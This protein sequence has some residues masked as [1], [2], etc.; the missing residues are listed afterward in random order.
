MTNTYEFAPPTLREQGT[1]RAKRPMRRTHPIHGLWCEHTEHVLWCEYIT[2][3]IDH[4]IIPR[5][6]LAFNDSINMY[7][8]ESQNTKAK[9][10]AARGRNTWRAFACGTRSDGNASVVHEARN[11]TSEPY[12]DR[13][14]LFTELISYRSRFVPNC[15][16]SCIQLV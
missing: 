2:N 14:V 1:A 3:L 11:V 10:R 4:L 8:R 12:R 7:I 9:C 15:S 5:M 13:S 6:N 16:P